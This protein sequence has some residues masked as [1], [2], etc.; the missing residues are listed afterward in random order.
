MWIISK[1]II[2]KIIYIWK[3][4]KAKQN[5]NIM[6]QSGKPGRENH[7]I[8]CLSPPHTAPGCHLCFPMDIGF[9]LPSLQISF[10][11]FFMHRAAYKPHSSNLGGVT[12]TNQVVTCP[13][14]LHSEHI[15]KWHFSA[16]FAVQFSSVTQSCPTLW[17]PM[18]CSTPGFPVYHQLPELVQIHVHQVSDAIQP[19]HPPAPSPPA[20]NLSS[21]RVFTNE[22]VLHIKWPKYWSFSFSISISPSSEYSG[23]ISLRIDW[24]DLLA[25]Q[26]TL[27]SQVQ[28][29]DELWPGRYGQKWY[30][31]FSRLAN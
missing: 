20:F 5:N 7:M 22:S 8:L 31:L 27:Y 16:S 1:A 19:S 13:F 29:Y 2:T 10:L 24:F 26:G 6:S 4:N 14:V 25:V 9:I 23:L 11:C 17:D 21:I 18:D 12:E 3:Q 28:S 30:I 15:M